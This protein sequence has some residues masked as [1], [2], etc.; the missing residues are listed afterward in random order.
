MTRQF[1]RTA[2]ILNSNN[3]K[4]ISVTFDLFNE[5]YLI[6]FF[7][8]IYIYIYMYWFLQKLDMT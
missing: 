8:K 7:Q 6:N 1:Q 4:V 5:S 3:L 2:F